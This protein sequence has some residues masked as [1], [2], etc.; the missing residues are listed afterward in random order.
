MHDLLRDVNIEGY[1]LTT[2]DTGRTERPSGSVTMDRAVLAYRFLA[3]NGTVLFEGADFY[4]SPMHAIDSDETLKGILGF[5]TLCPGD[6][7]ADYFANY[8]PA[9][10]AFAQ[11][12]AD[13]LSFYAMELE[14]GEELPGFVDWEERS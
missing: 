12:P 6:T 10:M 7:D 5:L 8:T 11:G 4:C 13:Q 1:R 2:W 9:Q 14:D 3:P